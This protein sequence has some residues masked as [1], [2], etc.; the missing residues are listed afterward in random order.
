MGSKPSPGICKRDIYRQRA[1][2][3]GAAS[4]C[5]LPGRRKSNPRRNFSPGPSAPLKFSFHFR[6]NRI[7]FRRVW[8]ETAFSVSGAGF[9]KI[10]TGAALE[11]TP[12]RTPNRLWALLVMGLLLG[13]PASA[14]S[15]AKSS[16]ESETETEAEC[17]PRKVLD[18]KNNYNDPTFVTTISP[19]SSTALGSSEASGTSGCTEKPLEGEEGGKTAYYK[20]QQQEFVTVTMDNI[21]EDVARGGGAHLHTL[22][23]LLGCPASGYAELAAMTRQLYAQLFPSAEIEPAEF[24]ARLK[25]RISENPRLAGSC[26]YA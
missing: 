10:L 1:I 13:S 17:Y 3:G 19:V 9:G 15:P 21:S 22:G 16:A 2:G 26:A 12:K 4:R 5:Q 7:S 25:S 14:Q 8:G 11:V 23:A 18:D 6:N 20:R 24:L